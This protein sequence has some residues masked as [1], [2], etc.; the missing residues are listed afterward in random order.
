MVMM[1]M[2][3][4][5]DKNNNFPLGNA[6]GCASLNIVCADKECCKNITVH[7]SE[8]FETLLPIST[9]VELENPIYSIKSP[10]KTLLGRLNTTQM[11][12]PQGSCFL[13]N[14]G[15]LTEGSLNE[16]GQKSLV[17]MSKMSQNFVIPY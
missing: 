9:E 17:S 2:V 14:V 4:K 5:S 6:L 13:V 10:M 15:G 7:L 1:S 11:K 8:K 3:E 12:L 16:N